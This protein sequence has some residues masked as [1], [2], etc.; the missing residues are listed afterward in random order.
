MSDINELISENKHL[1][2]QLNSVKH[3]LENQR[4]LL[5]EHSFNKY[6]PSIESEREANQILTNENQSLIAENASLKNKIDRL[7]ARIAGGVRVCFK[8]GVPTIPDKGTNLANATLLI[9]EQ[10]GKECVS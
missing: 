5:E 9:D 3:L 6:L 2:S 10:G 1:K 8:K 7:E 4:L